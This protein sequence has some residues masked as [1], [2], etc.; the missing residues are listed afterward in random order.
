MK[1]TRTNPQSSLPTSPSHKPTYTN[2]IPG[3][4]DSW[5]ISNPTGHPVRSQAQSGIY[6]QSHWSSCAFTG[7]HL[8][9]HW[10]LYAFTGMHPQ[11]NPKSRCPLNL[12]PPSRVLCFHSIYLMRDSTAQRVC[13]PGVDSILQNLC[14]IVAY[15]CRVVLLHQ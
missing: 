5:S 10:D 11:T 1:S 3:P 13:S 4:M 6:P 15:L 14:R 12:S 2:A 8:Q 7:M 9:Y